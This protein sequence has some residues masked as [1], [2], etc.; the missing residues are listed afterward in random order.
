MNK[1]IISTDERVLL[2]LAKYQEYAGE[3]H[4]PV[5]TTQKGI[6]QALGIS[7]AH[8]ATS[9]VPLVKDGFLEFRMARINGKKHKLYAYSVTPKGMERVADIRRFLE[10]MGKTEDS[11]ILNSVNKFV[12][13]MTLGER[14]DALEERIKE[15]ESRV[16]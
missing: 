2:H 5:E 10:R 15:L 11:V 12:A 14:I 8:A 4:A 16:I 13:S 1:N 3:Y 7:R 6:G 9:T